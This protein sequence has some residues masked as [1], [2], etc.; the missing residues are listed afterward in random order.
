VQ[1]AKAQEFLDLVQREMSVIEYA[2]KFLQLSRFGLYLIL[3]EE[4]KAKKFERGLN[5]RIRIMMSCFDIRDFSQLVDKASIYEESLKENV[6]E[7]ANQKRKTQGT[8]TS[9]GGAGPATRMAVGSFPPRGHKDIPMV[10]LQLR[11][12]G[13]KRRSCARSVTVCTR[14]PVG[15][16]P[17][18]AI[19]AASL[20]T[21]ARI[22]EARGCSEAFGT[23]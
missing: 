4:K 11:R 20:G 19:A 17:R 16:Q 18:L 1:E 2:T 23:S 15:W 3:T 14:G 10:T 6:A 5:S 7:Y 8:G 13:I 22:T 21:S 12:K 9:V